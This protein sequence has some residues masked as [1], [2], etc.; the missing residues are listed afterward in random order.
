MPFN[1][2][3]NAIIFVVVYNFVNEHVS[4][5]NAPPTTDCTEGVKARRAWT[6]SVSLVCVLQHRHFQLLLPTA[7]RSRS[8]QIKSMFTSRPQGS[9]NVKP[10]YYNKKNGAHVNNRVVRLSI[11][12]EKQRFSP[13]RH[14]LQHLLFYF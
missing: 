3:D 14:H 11:L 9:V 4:V 1:E 10:R 12:V 5:T 2:I 8:P 13:N 7:R 6:G